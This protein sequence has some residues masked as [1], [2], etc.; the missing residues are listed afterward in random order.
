MAVHW[1][2]RRL[3]EA[4]QKFDSFNRLVD[5][6]ATTLFLISATATANK[7]L[8]EKLVNSAYLDLSWRTILI[9]F[10]LFII[11]LITQVYNQVRRHRPLS[12]F[13]LEAALK[14][15]KNRTHRRR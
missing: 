10:S 7:I 1:K 11:L 12:D 6:A 4:I 2:H 9:C 15:H 5:L 3:L 14:A 13:E 8:P